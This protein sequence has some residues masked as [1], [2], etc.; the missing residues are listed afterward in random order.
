MGKLNGKVAIVT[1]AG[2]GTGKAFAIGLAK[3]GAKVV[4]TVNK[5]IEELNETVNEIKKLGGEALAVKADV[6]VIS[7][8]D[9]MVKQAT[10]KFGKI[11]VLV[12]NAGIYK[13]APFFEKTEADFDRVVAVN[14][15]G[16]FFCCQRVAKD[17]AARGIKGSI[18]NIS[19]NQA[20]LG[21]NVMQT[22]YTATK[23]GVNAL[24]RALAAELA[25]Y[26]IRVNTLGYGLTITEGVQ[27]LG[28]GVVKHLREMAGSLFPLKRVG[29]PDDYVG[30]ITWLASDESSYCTAATI[31]VDGGI[32]AI[33]LDPPH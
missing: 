24:T 21:V 22:D 7:D 27:E 5:R 31:N 25:K 33:Q 13:S 28:P 6:S 9:A 4:G 3:E 26:G 23:G 18:I 2:R 32:H 19:A 30:I 12:N 29:H 15:K 8:I 1:G 10:D 11:D 14:L 20:I 17:M 16:T